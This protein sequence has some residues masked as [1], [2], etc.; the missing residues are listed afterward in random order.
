MKKLIGFIS[1]FIVILLGVN[2]IDK[3]NYISYIEFY[4]KVNNKEIDTIFYNNSDKIKFKEKNNDTVFITELIIVPDVFISAKLKYLLSSDIDMSIAIVV[5][6][7]ILNSS[8]PVIP[9]ITMTDLWV[10]PVI[11]TPTAPS[12]FTVIFDIFPSISFCHCNVSL[13]IK[14]IFFPFLSATNRYFPFDSN[15]GVVIFTFI[16]VSSFP[17]ES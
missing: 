17:A 8:S 2:L 3:D 16:V 10:V 7:Y 5:D 1:L 4:K 14:Y 9:Y 11:T 12:L 6:K 15:I 13:Y